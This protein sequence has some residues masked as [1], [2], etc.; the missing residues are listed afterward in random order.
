MKKI[1][2]QGD[3]LLV[4]ISPKEFNAVKNLTRKDN[5]VAYGE[6]SGHKHQFLTQDVQIFVDEQ[7][8]QFIDVSQDSELV[9][10]SHASQT[11][12]QGYYKYVPQRELS[13]LNE[14]RRVID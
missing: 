13:L 6:V 8:R 4:G 1:H 7:D 2:R 12:S 11:I 10:D 14:V 5:I 9:H 3:V